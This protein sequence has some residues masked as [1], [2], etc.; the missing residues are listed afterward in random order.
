MVHFKKFFLIVAIMLGF[1]PLFTYAIGSYTPG[2]VVVTSTSITAAYNV[3]YNPNIT[4]G[5]FDFYVVNG[6]INIS[7]IDSTTGAG[8]SCYFNSSNPAYTAAEKA[9]YGAGNG[10]VITVYKPAGSAA[11]S[12]IVYRNASNSLD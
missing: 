2:T 6:G 3:R 9:A 4:Q 7:G 10:V 8:F 5:K 11:C 12:S 1:L